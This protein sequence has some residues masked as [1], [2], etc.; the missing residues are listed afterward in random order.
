MVHLYGDMTVM[1]QMCIHCARTILLH[2]TIPLIDF[3]QSSKCSHDHGLYIQSLPRQTNT[4]LFF[5]ILL[6]SHF[7]T[8]S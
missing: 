2:L 6:Q 4:L 8:I 7:P 5:V 3:L 1:T